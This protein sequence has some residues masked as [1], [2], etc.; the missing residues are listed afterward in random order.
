MMYRSCLAVV[1]LMLGASAA[2]QSASPGASRAFPG[3]FGFAIGDP[4]D[5]TRLQAAGF[6]ERRMGHPPLRLWVSERP[7]G[8][9]SLVS[10][11]PMSGDRIGMINAN[12]PMTR[13]AGRADSPAM[14]E[15]LLERCE[16]VRAAVIETT[17]AGFHQHVVNPTSTYIAER[18]EPGE[19]IAARGASR[20]ILNCLVDSSTG[21][22]NFTLQ[23]GRSDF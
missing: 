15:M 11:T 7:N 9:F 5:P 10:I 18:V 17:F 6:V 1:M 22:V 16:A 19:Q 20:V 4:V 12:A 3:A 14:R 13:P 21:Q 2:G 8:L 23:L